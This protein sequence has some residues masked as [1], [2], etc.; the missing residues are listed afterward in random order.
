MQKIILALIAMLPDSLISLCYGFK[1]RVMDGQRLNNKARLLCDIDRKMATPVRETPVETTRTNMERL[2]GAMTGRLPK[3]ASIDD[4]EIPTDFGKLPA[5]LYRPRKEPAQPVLVYYHGGGYIRGSLD[6][7]DGLCARLAKY[8]GFAVLSIAY[9]LA[10]ENKFPAAVDDAMSAFTWACQHG[11]D[12]GLDPKRVA[13]GG[14]SSGGCL[15]A[16]VAQQAK[17]QGVPSP[18]FQMLLYPTLDAHL[19][20]A[21]YQLFDEGFFLTY[22]R[23]R[24]YRDMYLNNASERD[25]L[26]ASPILNSDLA[27][28]PPALII[29]AGFD[30]LRDE[31]ES[32]GK[33]LQAAGVSVGTVRFPSMVHGFMSMTAILPQ[34]DKAIR[35]AADALRHIFDAK[36]F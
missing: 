29:S 3:L 33:A 13:V 11:A 27:D 32:Y 12:K 14:D 36:S 19:S 9:R 2:S 10:P 17:T 26:R 5:R 1:P 34:A 6:S 25:D 16:V 31:A 8:G 20:A 18:L 23:I 24:D 7:H 22:D 15:A 21:S 28:L 30:P 4:I 35:Q